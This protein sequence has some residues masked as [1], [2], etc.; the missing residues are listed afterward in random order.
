ML[1]ILTFKMFNNGEEDFDR[2][3][4]DVKQGKL[5]LVQ[6]VYSNLNSI[7]RMNMWEFEEIIRSFSF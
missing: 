3:H 7:R 5:V 6:P 1:F 2:Q 4:S